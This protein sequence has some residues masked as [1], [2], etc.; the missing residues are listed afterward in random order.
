MTMHFT[1]ASGMWHTTWDLVTT[2]KSNRN[3]GIGYLKVWVVRNEVDFSG[4][5]V[6]SPDIRMLQGDKGLYVSR[7]VQPSVQ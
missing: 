4:G 1:E 6:N 2:S 3:G 7:E 5:S